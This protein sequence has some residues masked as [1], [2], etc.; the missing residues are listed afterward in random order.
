MPDSSVGLCLL[1]PEERRIGSTV[2]KCHSHKSVLG[3][4]TEHENGSVMIFLSPY[5]KMKY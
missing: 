4:N 1:Q 3:L 5:W 2:I